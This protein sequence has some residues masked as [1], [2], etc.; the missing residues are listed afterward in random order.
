MV[1]EVPADLGVTSGVLLERSVR[2]KVDA[3]TRQRVD[4]KRFGK[5]PFYIRTLAT[6]GCRY[7]RCQVLSLHSN[8]YTSD[9]RWLLEG[10]A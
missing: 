9:S 6:L 3:I 1:R 4:T 2:G 8:V 7:E 10:T 5:D